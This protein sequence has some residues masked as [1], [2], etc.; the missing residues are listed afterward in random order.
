MK[1]ISIYLSQYFQ[2]PNTAFSA[3]R[4]FSYFSLS[5]HPF[6]YSLFCQ[7]FTFRLFQEAAADA[8]C[9]AGGDKRFAPTDWFPV[10]GQFL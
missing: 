3:G 10:C 2:S 6:F 1:C 5:S 8:D 7:I 9:E 4:L